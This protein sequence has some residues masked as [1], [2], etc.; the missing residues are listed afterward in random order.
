NRIAAMQESADGVL[1]IAS[2][3][4]GIIACVNGRVIATITQ[5][6]GLIGNVCHC[7]F[8]EG[9]HLWIGTDKG[10]N[11]IE[12]DKPGYPVSCYTA[13]DGLASDVVNEVYVPGNTVFV[14]TSAGLTY[15][16]ERKVRTADECG[17]ILTSL[18]SAD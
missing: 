5:R 3:D 6:N 11:K 17:L 7:L 9:H 4:K 15:F 13:R 10:L 8:W 12:L 18:T 14:G 16:D 1:W 2:Y